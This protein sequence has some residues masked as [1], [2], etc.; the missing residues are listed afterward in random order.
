[1]IMLVLLTHMIP[2]G[3]SLQ[4]QVNG[5]VCTVPLNPFL[6]KLKKNYKKYFGLKNREHVKRN[7]WVRAAALF[8]V[9]G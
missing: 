9:L 3:S 8:S 2:R 5:L 4:N 1:M 6:K 7:W